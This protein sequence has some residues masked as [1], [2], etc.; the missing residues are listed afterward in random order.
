MARE[1]AIATLRRRYAGLLAPPLEGLAYRF[2]IW[3]PILAQGRP[4]FSEGQQSYLN[5][6][7]HDCFVVFPSPASKAFRP[8]RA[9]GFLRGLMSR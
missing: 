6:L 2:T 4:V 3:L 8:G 1:D 7:F 9:L 5:G